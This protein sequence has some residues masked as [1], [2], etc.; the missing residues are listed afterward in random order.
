MAEKHIPRAEHHES[1]NKHVERE[2]HERAHNQIAEKA[3]H[4]RREKS[5]ENIEKI[6]ELANA[7]AETADAVKLGEAPRSESDSMVGMQHSLK[8][9]AYERTLARVQQRLPRATR[10]FSKA[11]HNP[12]VDTISTVGA[13]TVGRPSGLLGGSICAF[14]GSVITLYYS[15]H[16][17]FKYNYLVLFILFVGGY[18]IGSIIELL[19]WF[20]HG[21]KQRY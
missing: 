10:M 5:A 6:K 12:A 19:V 18:M 14:L 15:K 3:E 8:A 17:G 21:R 9:T 1:H 4:A 16:Y 7:H 2:H 13:E 11:V 20:F